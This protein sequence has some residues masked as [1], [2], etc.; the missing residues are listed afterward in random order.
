MF[1]CGCSEFMEENAPLEGIY[2]IEDAWDAFEGGD[3][4]EAQQLFSA[5]FVGGH[6]PYYPHAFVGL[7]W[8]CLYNA[9]TLIG[10]S[11]Y[12]DRYEQRNLAYD[13]FMSANEEF[14]NIEI[15]SDEELLQYLREVFKGH[16]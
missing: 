9:N 12:E 16:R 11:N 10:P 6:N 4:D 8:T 2:Y 1:I 5:T 7:G 13:Y 3:Y 15:E 14:E